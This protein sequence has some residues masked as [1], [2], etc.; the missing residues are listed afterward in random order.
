LFPFSDFFQG[1]TRRI[2]DITAKYQATA[3]G[4]FLQPNPELAKQLDSVLAAARDLGI[5]LDF[6]VDENGDPASECLRAVAEAVLRHSFPHPVACGHCCSLS[7]QDPERQRSTIELVKA[8]GIQ[9]I[10]L[11]LCNLY[12]QGRQK[13]DGRGKTPQWRGITLVHELLDAGV[14][15]ACASDNVRDAFYPWGD[16][17]AMDVF[18]QSFRI[19]HLDTKWSRS[20]TIVTTAPAKI[21]NLP[22]YGVIAPGSR[23]DLVVFAARSFSELLSVPG[24][25]RRLLQG[26]SFRLA[27]PPSYAE[28]D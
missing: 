18:N 19:G 2:V 25:P 15:V 13:V 27:Q 26:E 14:T 3:L 12:L 10:S 6:H 24:A 8:A 1:H 5:G 21:M 28:I 7:R 23:S 9:I 22:E 11:P 17:D 20:P 16:L 4:G